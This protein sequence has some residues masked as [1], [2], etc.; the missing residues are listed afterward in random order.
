MWNFKFL[1]QGI[2]A[3]VKEGFGFIKCVERDSRLFFHCCELLDPR[4]HVRM[5]DEVEFTVLPDPVAEKQRYY[6]SIVC[7]NHE[8][9]EYFVSR[10]YTPLFKKSLIS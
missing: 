3:A 8:N 9:K 5:S 2:V 6:F 10:F 4:H 7:L 1:L